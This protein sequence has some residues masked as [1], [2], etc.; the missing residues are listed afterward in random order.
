M[1]KLPWANSKV[2]TDDEFY[3]RTQEINN[4]KNLLM[5]T[6]Q[7]NAPNILLTGI[8]GVGKTVLL[9]KIK[10]QMDEKFLVVY[11]DFSISQTYQKNNMSIKGLLDFYYQK[12]IL[13]HP[14]SLPAPPNLPHRNKG[15]AT[16]RFC[17]SRP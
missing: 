17:P 2:L 6:S 7:N 11:M 14:I 8:R 4:L 3:N 12:I 5:S 16:R 13:R 10:Q 15:S 9:N 1:S